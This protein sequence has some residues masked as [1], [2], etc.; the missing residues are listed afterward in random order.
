MRHAEGLGISH[1]AMLLRLLAEE[2]RSTQTAADRAQL[3]WSGTEV[4]GAVTRDS[5][6]VV[7]ELFR[8]ARHSVLVASFAV[9]HGEKAAVLFGTLAR[10]MDAEPGLEVRFFVNIHRKHGDSTSSSDLVRQFSETFRH[11]I[12]PGQ[13]LPAVYYDKR[14]LEVATDNRAC[15]HAKCVVVDGERALITSANFTEA[16]H[17]RN[18]E[19]GVLLADSEVATALRAQFEAL[20]GC[21]L[22]CRLP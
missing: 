14:S 1:A 18:I 13:R 3:V 21:G 12:W 20:V 10:R 15:L 17:T 8:T 9:D 2:R 5:A 7:Q 6:V 19:V 11:Q 4:A 16:A 22:L